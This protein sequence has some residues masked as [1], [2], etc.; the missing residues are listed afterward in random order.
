MTFRF[1]AEKTAVSTDE[2][3]KGDVVIPGGLYID[4]YTGI[5]Q[6]RI[7]DETAHDNDSVQHWIYPP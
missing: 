3:A 2:L 7:S 4:N 6:L 1:G 5:A